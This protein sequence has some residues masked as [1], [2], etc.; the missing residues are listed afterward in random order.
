MF[1]VVSHSCVCGY[2]F[3]SLFS[4]TPPQLGRCLMAMSNT[5]ICGATKIWYYVPE[6]RS[7]AFEAW[8]DATRPGYIENIE[9]GDLVFDVPIVHLYF[10]VSVHPTL[11]ICKTLSTF[12][13]KLWLSQCVHNGKC[14]KCSFHHSCP[15]RRQSHVHHLVFCLSQAAQQ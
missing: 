10:V 7:G 5:M 13:I 4:H 3:G 8:L 15:H 6:N 12:Q 14:C 9:A 2:R 11:C 1:V